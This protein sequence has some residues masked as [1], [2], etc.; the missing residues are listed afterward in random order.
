MKLTVWTCTSAAIGIVAEGVDVDATL[1][2][3]II[4]CNVPGDGSFG[5]LGFLLEGH[6]ALDVAIT[7]EDCDC[8]TSQPYR[9]SET[10]ITLQRNHVRRRHWL[11]A[12]KVLNSGT[13]RGITTALAEMVQP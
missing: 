10:Q 13:A 7:T 11:T 9:S 1:S 5:S 12:I 3:G 2:V 8:S 4:A 6:G